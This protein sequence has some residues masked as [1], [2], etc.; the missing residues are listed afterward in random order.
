M[1]LVSFIKYIFLA[2]LLGLLGIIIFLD[3]DQSFRDYVEKQVKKVFLNSFKSILHGRVKYVWLLSGEIELEN[4]T[5]NSP[6]DTTWQ[7]KADKFVIQ[8]SWLSFFLHNKFDIMVSLE[9]LDAFSTLHNSTI[10]IIEHLQCFIAGAEGFPATLKML[11]I[12]KGHFVLNDHARALQFETLFNGTY[13]NLKGWYRIHL[14]FDEGT[15]LQQEQPIG[16]NIEGTLHI[17]IPD[18]KNQVIDASM[19]TKFIIPKL[20]SEKNLCHL[21]GQWH[22]D[23]GQLLVHTSDDSCSLTLYNWSK[24]L[25][26]FVGDIACNI[27]LEYCNEFIPLIKNLNIKGKGHC[28]AH[29][30]IAD[31][32]LLQ[33]DI[34]LS[35]MQ[36]C[37]NNLGTL[38]ASIERKENNW[39]IIP[40]YFSP[41][42]RN[43]DVQGEISFQ[44]STKTATASFNNTAALRIF[45]NWV[46]EQN[47]LSLNASLNDS[48]CTSSFHVVCTNTQ[49]NNPITIE[50]ICAITSNLCTINGSYNTKKFELELPFNPYPTLS[51]FLLYEKKEKPLMVLQNTDTSSKIL[52]AIDFELIQELTN[53][54]GGFKIPGQG[55]LSLEGSVNGTTI[56][57]ALG[58]LDGTIRVPGTYT[59]I[60]G[61]NGSVQADFMHKNI[62]FSD[63]FL[64]L[65]KG[66]LS[67]KRAVVQLDNQGIPTFLYAPCI[68]KKAFLTLQKELFAVFSGTIVATKTKDHGSNVKGKLIIDRGYL[69]KNIFSQFSQQS[70][71]LESPLSMFS[72]DC[73]LDISLET[74]NPLEV[75]TSFLETNI[76]MALSLQGTLHN[77][78]VSGSLSLENGT[79]SFPYRPLTLTHGT[80]YF[81]P[82]QLLDP[83]IELIAKGKIRKYQ[84]TLRCNGSLQH[85]HIS[86]ESSP[87]LTEEQVITL[88]L[89]GSEEGSLSLAMPAF[90]MQKLQNV[91]FGPEQPASKLEGYF[92]SLLSPLK[93]IRF[94][95]G[96]SDQS[97]RG[98]FRG[99]IEIDVNDQLRGIIQKNFSLSEDI[100]LEV[101][102]F[103][104]DDITIR[105]MRDERGDYGG[106]VEMRWKF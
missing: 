68:I 64:H 104:S 63:L 30:D 70:S 75:K 71:G 45:N 48:L 1:R 4:V 96:F 46:I 37:A 80:I 82:H 41:L 27:P 8:F 79:L 72:D 98:G 83:A 88:L 77:P 40:R 97:G 66:S 13:G 73:S 65:D 55:T 32:I 9:N 85:P 38:Q 29:I 26:H 76:Q 59:I 51:K 49:T 54:F 28:Q 60:R 15:F 67:C 92:K 25:D 56:S 18:L 102:Y 2:L 78:E 34:T 100:K 24:T 44:E 14:T 87:P 12:N 105:G 69:K 62:I 5:V 16:N 36:C 11:T 20:P 7:W 53:T 21:D 106:E 61:I 23:A 101:E 33:G 99:S 43:Q 42:N 89:A 103:L 91:I 3:H 52:G 95:P 94:I 58:L 35:D 47:K 50:G 19:C 84:V 81:L 39:H 74:K 10:A 90:V 31:D 17:S 86:F 93:H 22:G 57:A 6:H